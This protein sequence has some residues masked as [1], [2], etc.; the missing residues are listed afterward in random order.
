M[1]ESR[2]WLPVDP[3]PAERAGGLWC[4]GRSHACHRHARLCTRELMQS[5]IVGK[6]GDYWKVEPVRG[7]GCKTS[8]EALQ[9]H[10]Y[11]NRGGGVGVSEAPMLHTLFTHMHTQTHMSVDGKARALNHMCPR[12]H[13]DR[14]VHILSGCAPISRINERPLHFTVKQH[15]GALGNNR[16]QP[17]ISQVCLQ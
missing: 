12:T 8:P 3:A 4:C 13:A 5:E 6:Y 9:S 2:L 14:I 17:V 7:D 10:I 11:S 1:M 15:G 16:L